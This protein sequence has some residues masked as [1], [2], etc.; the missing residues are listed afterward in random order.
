MNIE[1]YNQI[2]DYKQDPTQRHVPRSKEK[3]K[4]YEIFDER[5]YRRTQDQ[6]LQ[7]IKKR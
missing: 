4:N 3:S 2:F 1:E 7:V 5:L 6:L